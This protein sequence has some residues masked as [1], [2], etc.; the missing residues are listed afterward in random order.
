MKYRPLPDNLTIKLSPIEGFGIFAVENIDK[1][2]DL[3]ISHLS[4]GR[5]IYRTPLGGF[6]NHSENPNCLL[7]FEEEFYWLQTL[8][9]VEEGTELTVNYNKYDVNYLKESNA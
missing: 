3:G 4:L 7:L 9:S 8:S 6:L 5:E 2:T 1:M